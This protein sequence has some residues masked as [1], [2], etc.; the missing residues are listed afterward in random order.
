MKIDLSTLEDILFPL[1]LCLLMNMDKDLLASLKF[2][3]RNGEW[4]QSVLDEN[5][6]RKALL[7]KKKE[8]LG[9]SICW[10]KKHSEACAL[11]LD[12][13][14]HLNITGYRNVTHLLLELDRSES[15]DNHKT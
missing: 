7:E 9:A 13:S 8:L 4:T 10:Q 5:N 15:F 12:P 3:T 6:E 2:I 14:C 1:R 11:D